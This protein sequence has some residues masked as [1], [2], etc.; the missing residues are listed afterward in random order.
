RPCSSWIGRLERSS[1]RRSKHGAAGGSA[2][3]WRWASALAALAQLRVHLKFA[4]QRDLGIHVRLL[5][6][7]APVLQFVDRNDL[8]GDGAANERTGRQ[9]L[10]VAVQIANTCFL[11]ARAFKTVHHSASPF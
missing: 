8:A 11:A 5:P 2:I 9:D 6:R 1:S 7:D 4:L 3:N 10:K